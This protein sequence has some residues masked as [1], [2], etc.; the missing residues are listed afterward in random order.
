M[1]AIYLNTVCFFSRAT[2]REWSLTIE[3]EIQFNENI[4]SYYI[5]LG[6]YVGIKL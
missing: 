4:N 3:K 6:K 5:L 1:C 2:L